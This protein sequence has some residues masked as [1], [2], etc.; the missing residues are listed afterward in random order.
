MG[1]GKARRTIDLILACIDIL[2]QIQPASVRAV[3]YQLFT[4]GLIDSM[5]KANTNRVSTQLVWAR[6][7]GYLRWSWIVD[8]TR[9]PEYADTWDDPTQ[10]IED[11]IKQYRKDRWT[12]QPQQVEVWSEK[13]TVR[14]TLRPVLDEY[15][16]TFRVM[17]G[18]GSATALYQAAAYS[19]RLTRPLIVLYCGD[20]DPSG[21][22][23]SEIDLPSRLQEYGANIDLRRV[24]LNHW[25]TTYGELPGFTAEDKH[26]DARCAWFRERYGEDCWELD[27]LSPRLLR[28][29]VA[30]AIL[31]EIDDAL[32][33]QAEATEIAE[34]ESLEKIL[35]NWNKQAS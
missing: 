11:T 15:G 31:A 9:E 2:E 24:A 35:A 13:G 26:L 32:W 30:D 17:H 7:Q 25:D 14:G 33:K 16:V 10:L 19:R 23:M 28:E 34:Q 22:H 8:E 4:R 27:A 5:A 18:Y 20:W 1:R 3:C 6:E 21:M 29:R 12:L